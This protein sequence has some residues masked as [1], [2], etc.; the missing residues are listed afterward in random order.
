[1]MKYLPRQC[2][3]EYV[4]GR[5]IPMADSR[6]G[7]LAYLGRGPHFVKI[8]GRACYTQRW[9]DSWIRAEAAR[10]VRRRRAETFASA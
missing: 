4:R 10:P 3:T 6:L 8:N 2:A 5:G 1:M 7:D 9:L